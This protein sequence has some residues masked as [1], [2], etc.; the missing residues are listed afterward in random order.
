MQRCTCAHGRIVTRH[1]HDSSARAIIEQ[2]PREG[3]RQSNGRSAHAENH[4]LKLFTEAGRARCAC[5][6]TFCATARIPEPGN[7]RSEIRN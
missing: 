2:N 5:S 4:L 1:L 3:G 7:R 6:T